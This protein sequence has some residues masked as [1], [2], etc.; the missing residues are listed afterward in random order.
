MIRL[1][2]LIP[3]GFWPSHRAVRQGALEL[4][5]SGG[6]GSGKSSYLSLE[7]LLQLLRHPDC[8]AAVLRKVANT[9]RTSV[10]TQLLWAARMLG[11]QHHFRFTLNPLEATYL[12][13][14]Q[15]ILFLGMD[16]PGKLKSLKMPF[17]YIGILWLEEL[18][19][20]SPEDVPFPPCAMLCVDL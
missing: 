20:F 17:G 9:L 12:P 16:D 13:T 15:K 14:G 5:E 6:R 3:P 11:L 10:F 2:E 19:Q 18:D 8:H 4:L 7:L 1:S